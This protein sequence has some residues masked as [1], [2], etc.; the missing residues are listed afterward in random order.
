MTA[1]ETA[2][3]ALDLVTEHLG[4]RPVVAVVYSHSHA[5]HLGGVRGIVEEADV[6]SGNDRRE[7]RRMVI[8]IGTDA[9]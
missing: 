7:C 1:K 2:A 3:A 6:R 9:R 4:E 5:D 8:K